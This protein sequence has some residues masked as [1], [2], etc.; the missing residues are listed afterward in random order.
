MLEYGRDR[1][2]LDRAEFL[3]EPRHHH[4]ARGV[5]VLAG[6]VRSPG[7]DEALA[8][9]DTSRRHCLGL[10]RGMGRLGRFRPAKLGNLGA[11][12]DF[13][14]SVFRRGTPTDPLQRGIVIPG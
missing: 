9:A 12:H 2:V 11:Y 4:A 1:V 8:R 3:S 10:L 7:A 13:N 14:L 5:N 6:E